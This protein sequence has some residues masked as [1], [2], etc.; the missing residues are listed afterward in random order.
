MRHSRA[1][2]F[3]ALVLAVFAGCASRSTSGELRGEPVALPERLNSIRVPLDVQEFDVVAGDDGYRGVFV[4]LTGLPTG[5]THSSQNDPS[6]IVVTIAGA[7]GT[8]SA[9]ETFAAGDDVVTKIMLAR[10]TGY[11]QVVLDLDVDVTP[12]YEVLPMADWVLVRI[13]STIPKKPWAHRAS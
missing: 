5:V 13:K 10:R 11:L 9:P 2:P 8:E 1:L 6:R 4:K 12:E 7:T 3:A